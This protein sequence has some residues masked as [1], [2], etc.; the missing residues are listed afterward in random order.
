[1]DIRFEVLAHKDRTM[2]E[3]D[4][5]FGFCNVATLSIQEGV[6]RNSEGEYKRFV[7]VAELN[8][9]AG[10]MRDYADEKN[11]Y[12]VQYSGKEWFIK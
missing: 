4:S 8:R 12:S 10:F 11:G 2:E 6:E 7:V 3:L 5:F 9:N 1:M